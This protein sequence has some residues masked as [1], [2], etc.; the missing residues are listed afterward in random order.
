[1]PERSLTPLDPRAA[2]DRVEGRGGLMPQFDSNC[3][4]FNLV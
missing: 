4:D 1:M 3:I 2:S